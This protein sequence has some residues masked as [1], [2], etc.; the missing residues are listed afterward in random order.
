MRTVIRRRIS[1]ATLPGSRTVLTCYRSGCLSAG[2]G[3]THRQVFGPLPVKPYRVEFRLNARGPYRVG[4][5]SPFLPLVKRA[6]PY[7]QVH[8]WVCFLPKS[9]IG[10]RI[11]RRVLPW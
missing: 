8:A 2:M 1:V 11:S 9:W 5:R 10:K 7:A 6:L 3:L 4:G